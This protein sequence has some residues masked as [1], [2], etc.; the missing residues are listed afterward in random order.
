M[1]IIEA[2][3]TALA[4]GCKLF[5]AIFRARN[6]ASM[7]AAAKAA[8]LQKIKDSVNQHIQSGDLSAVQSD[9]SS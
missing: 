9:G 4:E 3:G 5:L 1:G 2:V 7:Q 6:S 8:T